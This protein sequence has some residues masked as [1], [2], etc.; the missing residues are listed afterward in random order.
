MSIIRPYVFSDRDRLL[1]IWHE[2]SRVGHPFLSGQDL[3]DQKA[4]VRDIYL[5][6]AENWVALDG[7]TI[8]G[9]IGLLGS[10][11]GGL[12]VHPLAHKLG[13]GRSLVEHAAA[14]KGELEVEVYALNQ[15]ALRFYRKLAFA[16]VG[17]RPTDDQGRPLE[18][19]RLRRNQ[20]R[21]YASGEIQR[22]LP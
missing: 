2:A 21:E 10:F 6:Q 9:F 18:I 13:V 3:E 12:F 20:R 17:R 5:P 22:L 1:K 11:I 14:I 7:G 19:V 4:L 16:K 15:G 8:V